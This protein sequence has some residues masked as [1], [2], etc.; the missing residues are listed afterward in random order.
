MVNIFT[1]FHFLKLKLQIYIIFDSN[2][3][4]NFQNSKFVNMFLEQ[5]FYGKH[6]IYLS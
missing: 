4:E 6:I 2:G 5:C 1:N 3:F